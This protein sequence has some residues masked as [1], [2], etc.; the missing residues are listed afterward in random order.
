MKGRILTEKTISEFEK[1]LILEE[2]SPVTIEKY[3]RDVTA[4][5]A[6]LSDRPVSK[7]FPLNTNNSL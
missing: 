4:F 2:K 7:E 5:M 3:I 1:H 6:F